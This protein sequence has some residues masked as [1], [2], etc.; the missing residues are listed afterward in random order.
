MLVY[1]RVP[2]FQ[3]HPSY[4]RNIMIIDQQIQLSNV[5]L[6]DQYLMISI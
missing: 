4:A 3:T 5:F 1:Q 6:D 2:I